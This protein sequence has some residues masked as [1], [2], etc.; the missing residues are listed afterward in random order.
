MKYSISSIKDDANKTIL[1]ALE[2]LDNTF[3]TK[4]SYSED[5]KKT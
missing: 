3:F 5:K 2:D 1:T 4:Y